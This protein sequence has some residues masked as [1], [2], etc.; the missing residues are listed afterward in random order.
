MD[1]EW[2]YGSEAAQIYRTIV[3]GRPNGMP[4]WAG[5]IP[6][7]Q[8][9]QIVAYVRSLSGLVPSAVRNSRSDHM[10]TFPEA[11]TLEERAKPKQAFVPPA[12]KA[13]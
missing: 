5:R 11:M 2:I 9:W 3:E 13:P 6:D 12:S 1:D 8:V 4:S 7:T 10:M